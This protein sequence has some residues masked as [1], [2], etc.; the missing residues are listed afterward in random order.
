MAVRA[1]RSRQPRVRIPL[2]LLAVAACGGDVTAP[3][4]GGDPLVLEW[5]V[6]GVE[7]VDWV[8]NNYVDLQ[9]GSGLRDYRGGVKTYDGH[10]GVDIDVPN[11]RWMDDDHPVVAAHAGEVVAV[12]DS[13]PDRNT[14]CVGFWNFVRIR[15]DDGSVLIYG[16]LKQGSV[17][18][19]VGQLVAAGDTLGVVGSSGCSTQPHLHLELLGPSGSL[20]DPFRDGLWA[21]E[22]A[23]DPPLELMDLSLKDGSISGLDELKD[24]EPNATA[25]TLGGTLG[26]GLSMSG[27]AAGDVVRVTVEDG[28]GSLVYDLT[29]TFPQPYRHSYWYWNRGPLQ[30]APGTWTVRVHADGRLRATY[31]FTAA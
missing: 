29:T 4:G 1:A 31:T 18:V 30:G 3:P 22:P 14:S 23:Y 2:A 15:H 13:E 27:G 8:I 24:P 17:A 11:F 21:S 26:V 9:P 28:G 16:H 5:P 19:P 20:L 7:G 25:V 6:P 10:Q 12:H